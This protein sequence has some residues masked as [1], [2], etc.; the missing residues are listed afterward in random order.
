VNDR[1]KEAA[2]EGRNGGGGAGV[3]FAS[4]PVIQPIALRQ[5]EVEVGA[6]ARVPV[7]MCVRAC[8]RACVQVCVSVCVSVC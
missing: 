4:Q 1:Q 3:V 5:G 7:V 8:V 6:R 2:N